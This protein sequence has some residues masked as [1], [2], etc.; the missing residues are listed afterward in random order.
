MVTALILINA[1]RE[2]INDVAETLAGIQSISEVYSVTGDYDLVA[3]VR[4]KTNDEIADLVT[5]QLADVDG[6][7]HTETMMAFRVYSRHDLESMFSL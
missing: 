7:E 6:I 5:Q 1:E 4:V 3:I 2:K